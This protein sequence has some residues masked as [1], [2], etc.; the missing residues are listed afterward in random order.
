MP[1]ELVRFAKRTARPADSDLL[2][3]DCAGGKGVNMEPEGRIDIISFMA[4]I[5]DNTVGRLVDLVCTAHSEGSTEVRLY[6]SS[7]GG[8]LHPAFTAYHFL[9]ALHMPFYTHNVGT[10]ENGG[11]LLYLASD[12]RSS[13]PNAKFM[14]YNFEWTFYRD[15]IRYPEI[16]EAYE[17][18]KYDVEN[19]SS[20]FNERTNGSFDI[21]SCLCGPACVMDTNKALNAGI[22]TDPLIRAPGI[23]ELAKIWSVHN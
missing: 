10:L 4:P 16:I 1:I 11:L 15:H 20:L 14:F 2:R 22:I 13:S 3:G 7:V 6:I 18:L 19:Y 21:R 9:R 17:S 5:N 23:P 8:K 12:Q